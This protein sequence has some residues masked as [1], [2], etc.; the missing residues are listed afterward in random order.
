MKASE[1]L[2]KIDNILIEFSGD[3]EFYDSEGELLNNKND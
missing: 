3:Y 1:Y 2:E